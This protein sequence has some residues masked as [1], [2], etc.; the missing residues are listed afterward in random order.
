M[1]EGKKGVSIRDVRDGTS[2]TVMLVEANDAEAVPWTKPDDF[3]V[4]PSDPKKGLVGAWPDGF[5]LGL[6]DGSTKFVP[7]SVDP[8]VLKAVF[9]YGGGEQ[10]ANKIHQW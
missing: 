9:S 7:A 6:A 5:L 1:F 4:D 2:N 8:A 10:D 3:E